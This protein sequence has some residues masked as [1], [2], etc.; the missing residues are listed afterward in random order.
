MLPSH[1]LWIASEFPDLQNL[2]PIAQGGQKLVLS[3]NHPSDGHVVL[4]L[5]H[6]LQ[7]VEETRR[8]VAAVAQIASPRV[9]AVIDVGVINSPMGQTVWIREQRIIGMTLRELLQH[10]TLNATELLKLA[11]QVL[12]VLRAA[13]TA[14][15]VHRD[16]K[17]ENII[18][19]NNGDFWVLDFGI[20]RHLSMVAITPATRPFGKFTLGYAPPE[21]VRNL[22]TEIDSSADLFA[23][24]VTLYECSTG[25]NPFR[26]G[27]ADDFE[28]LRR[29]DNDRLPGL[30][31]AINDA[32]SFAD[33][34]AAMT[35]KKRHH[36]PRTVQQ[37][38]DWM[39]QITNR[40]AG[41]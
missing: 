3:A 10:R 9:P 14:L 23:L 40:Q 13:E 33:L 37:A 15:I 19:D 34:I 7:D 2:D 17:P 5:I 1:L 25:V 27:A 20:S 38:D 41:P 16:I 8:E 26:H 22:Q 21:Q 30:V 29:I 6:P 31:M 4:K 36:R 35:Q 11:S 18:I 24:G 12:E 39:L 32:N 28:I